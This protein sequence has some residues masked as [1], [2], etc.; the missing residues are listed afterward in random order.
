MNPHVT[1][2]KVAFSVK[3]EPKYC[4]HVKVFAEIHSKIIFNLREALGRR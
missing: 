2:Q 4:V 3:Q 1:V